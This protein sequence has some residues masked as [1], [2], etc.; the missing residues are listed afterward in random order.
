M[1]DEDAVRAIK[2]RHSA[3]LLALPGVSGV[4]VEKDDNGDFVLA[5]HV[6][7]DEPAVRQLVPDQIEGCPVKRIVTGP[8]RKFGR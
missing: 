7:S 1:P 8:Y 3:T 2:R 6:N 4:G 5:V